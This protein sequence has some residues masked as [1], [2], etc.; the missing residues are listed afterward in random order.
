MFLKYYIWF[1]IIY[2][3]FLLN[4]VYYLKLPSKL[5]YLFC[6][7]FDIKSR[8]YN[9]ILLI[10]FTSN[11][12]EQVMNFY[13]SSINKFN[14]TDVLFLSLDLTGY[15]MVI[16][17]LPNVY[18]S[19]SHHNISQ[20][21]D[22]N[23]PLYWSIVYS[24]TNYVKKFIDNNISIIMCDSDLLFFKDPREYMF[25]YDTDLITSCDHYCPIMNSGL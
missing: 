6:N 21:I 13:Y 4:A 8:K 18:M 12:Y 1:I 2:V 7:D 17:K 10:V 11:I 16:N 3:Y 9:T 23:T 15:N 19:C 5:R 20:Y 22:Y 14:I 24:K 25:K